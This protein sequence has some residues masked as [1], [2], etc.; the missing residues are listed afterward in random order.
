MGGAVRGAG[1]PET[2]RRNGDFDVRQSSHSSW[3]TAAPPHA[4]ARW[5]I[6]PDAGESM[7]TLNGCHD[8]SVGAGARAGAAAVTTALALALMAGREVAVNGRRDLSAE[9]RCPG[10]EPARERPGV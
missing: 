7:A 5:S 8:T 10:V 9:V 1:P 3:P 4:H 6:G 2:H